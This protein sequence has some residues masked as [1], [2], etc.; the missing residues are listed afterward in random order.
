MHHPFDA[1]TVE[2]R[3]VAR[4]RHQHRPTAVIRY[5]DYPL[6]SRHDVSSSASTVRT[7]QANV[8]TGFVSPR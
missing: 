7:F 2:E 3:S 4:D 5:R 6:V 1:A 8:I